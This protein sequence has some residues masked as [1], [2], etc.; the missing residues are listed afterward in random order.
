MH[1]ECFAIASGRHRYEN[2]SFA[3]TDVSGCGRAGEVV[4]EI[5]NPDAEIEVE[6]G[7]VAGRELLGRT[8]VLV[9]GAER[10]GMGETGKAILANRDRDDGVEPQEREIGQIVSCETL[11]AKVGMNET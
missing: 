9:G 6:L 7:R 10:G 3:R 4:F 11:G 5:A 1:L 2:G 8:A